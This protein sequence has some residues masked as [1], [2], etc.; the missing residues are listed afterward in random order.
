MEL[1]K[2]NLLANKC[3]CG[4]NVRLK[5]WIEVDEGEDI[6]KAAKK[7]RDDS[8]WADFAICKCGNAF[9]GRFKEN[10]K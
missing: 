5:Q 10:T 7:A 4:E 1:I 3:S 9:V 6:F 2:T 8:R